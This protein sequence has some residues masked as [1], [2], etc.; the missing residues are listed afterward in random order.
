MNA[1]LG[2]QVQVVAFDATT[3]AIELLREGDVSLVI[4]Q[5]PFD[6][7]YMAVAFAWPTGRV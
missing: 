1:G 3:F 4:A 2:G 5:K 7:G 6:M